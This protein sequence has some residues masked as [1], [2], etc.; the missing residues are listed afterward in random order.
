[1]T[2]SVCILLCTYNG[3]KYLREQIESLF[4]QKNVDM[5]IMA[6]DDGS[7]D[8]TADILKEYNIPV[9]GGGHLG[10]AHGF[11]YLMEQAP[12]A[13]FYAFCDQDDIWDEDKISVAVNALGMSQKPMIYCSSTRLVSE[14]GAFVTTHRVDSSRT[15]PSRLF[16]SSI[17]GNTI[18][19]NSSMRD[20]AL[21]HHPERM[22]MHDSW[23]VKLCIAVGGRLII[24][25][26]AHIDYRMHGSNTVGMELN[27]NQK[28]GKFKRVVNGQGEGQ[29]LID[30]CSLYGLMVKPEYRMLAADTEKSRTDPKIRA[31]FM[32]EHGIDFKN[33]GF[34]MAFAMKVK[35]GNL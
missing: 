2:H 22:V 12:K 19:F 10:A 35:K 7:T 15:L 13:D 20:V 5:A 9:F 27:L 32:K 18:V 11:F 28:I 4:N 17:S 8:G 6:H 23:L 33:R 29:E 14:D 30:I 26:D 25:E 3:E 21:M 31:N 16:Y 1:M 34:N 24:D